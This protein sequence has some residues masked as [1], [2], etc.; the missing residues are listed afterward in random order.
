[1]FTK[2]IHPIDRLATDEP[3]IWNLFETGIISFEVADIMTNG[4]DFETATLS[5]YFNSVAP[6]AFFNDELLGCAFC[7]RILPAG[8]TLCTNCNE[9]DGANTWSEFDDM[10]QADWF[11]GHWVRFH[12]P[13][14]VSA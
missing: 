7:A 1:M 13:V 2:T 9:L 14:Q 12:A 5:A 11:A 6:S 3:A 4:Y 10:G 8:E